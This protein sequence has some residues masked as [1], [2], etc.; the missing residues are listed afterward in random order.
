MLYII[1]EQ[2]VDLNYLLKLNIIHIFRSLIKLRLYKIFQS[3]HF[4]IIQLP[5]IVQ[6][7]LFRWFLILR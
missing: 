1:M 2:K 5:F 3:S 4:K 6:T 7:K